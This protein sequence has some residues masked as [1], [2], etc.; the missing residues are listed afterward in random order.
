MP[1]ARIFD[2][3]VPIDLRPSHAPAI[4]WVPLDKRDCVLLTAGDLASRGCAA[5]MEE[6]WTK[7]SQGDH[8]HCL[9]GLGLGAENRGTGPLRGV[10]LCSVAQPLL[11]C[12]QAPHNAFPATLVPPHATLVSFGLHLTCRHGIRLQCNCGRA[13]YSTHTQTTITTPKTRASLQQVNTPAASSRA[14]PIISLP[15]APQWTASS[16]ARVPLI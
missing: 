10:T 13:F 9:L 2:I 8:H 14:G 1:L 11:I 7:I 16:R 5:K 4:A 6:T 15:D 12:E 3:P